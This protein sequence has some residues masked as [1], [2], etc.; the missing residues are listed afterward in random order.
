MQSTIQPQAIESSVRYL[1]SSAN[2]LI[3][4][5]TTVCLRI[6]FVMITA[7]LPVDLELFEA[8]AVPLHLLIPLFF[9]QCNAMFMLQDLGTLGERVKVRPDCFPVIDEVTKFTIDLFAFPFSKLELCLDS[10]VNAFRPTLVPDTEVCVV[11]KVFFQSFF[12]AAT[13]PNGC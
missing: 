9:G 5:L 2:W 6:C 11:R 3:G 13:W 12:C 10:P 1:S 8:G 7:P 4:F